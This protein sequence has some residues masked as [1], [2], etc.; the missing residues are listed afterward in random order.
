MTKETAQPLPRGERGESTATAGGP[1]SGWWRAVGQR[2]EDR[3]AALCAPRRDYPRSARSAVSFVQHLPLCGCD[4]VLVDLLPYSAAAGSGISYA[5]DISPEAGQPHQRHRGLRYILARRHHPGGGAHQYHSA[6][7]AHSTSR[8]PPTS[9]SQSL[10]TRPLPSP[11]GVA[12][13]WLSERL[14]P[15]PFESEQSGG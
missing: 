12:K 1:P 11:F 7:H 2:R 9:P 13:T 8:S 15:G 5:G 3:L 14:N 4:P 6:F 10:S